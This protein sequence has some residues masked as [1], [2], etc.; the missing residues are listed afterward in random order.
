MEMHCHYCNADLMGWNTGFA[1]LRYCPACGR[2]IHKPVTNALWR[3][4]TTDEMAD[5]I[6]EHVLEALE[7][8]DLPDA[9]EL[10]LLAWERENADGVVFY[11]NYRAEQ[12][13]I[14]HNEW[15]DDALAYMID[16]FGSERTQIKDRVECVDRFLVSAF[17]LATKHYLY[18]QLGIDTGEGRL[19]EERREELK[20]LVKEIRYD[21]NF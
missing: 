12:F 10:D 13:T 5:T 17:I 4:C 3:L 11:A 7:N 9:G 19:T 14:R 6:E 21:G 2:K 8:Y 18:E 1:A 20:R 16:E 15:V